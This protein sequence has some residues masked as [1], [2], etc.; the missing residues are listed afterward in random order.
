MAEPSIPIPGE[1]SYH[2]VKYRVHSSPIRNGSAP[3]AFQH[4]AHDESQIWI[5]EAIFGV[6]ELRDG[7]WVAADPETLNC[8]PRAG[9]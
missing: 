2:K 5:G 6:D 1:C 7:E 3:Q 8:V 4:C 9:V